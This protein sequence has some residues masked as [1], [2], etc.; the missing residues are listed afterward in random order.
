MRNNQKQQKNVFLYKSSLQVFYHFKL[1][2]NMSCK[3]TGN[4]SFTE[5]G[6]DIIVGYFR[7]WSQ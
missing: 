3:V 2:Y 4:M 5:Y 1:P 6:R 7:C